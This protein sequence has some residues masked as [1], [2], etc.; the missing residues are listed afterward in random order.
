VAKQQIIWSVAAV[1]ALV[2]STARA[3]IYAYTDA[4]GNA[5]FSNVPDDQRYK[6]VVRTPVDADPA[7]KAQPERTAAWLAR[8]ASFDR[9]IEAAAAKTLVSP[10]LL[11]AVIVV[12]SGF[13]PRAISR[14]GAIGLMQLMPQT[15]RRYGAFNAFDPEQNIRAGAQYLADLML[16]FG[17]DKLELVIAA[18]NAGEGAVEKYGRKIPPY[19]ETRAYVPNVLRMYRVLQAQ[20][21]PLSQ[22]GET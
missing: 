15:A 11:R 21:R 10:Q 3:D 16:R 1:L 9:A 5:H 14:R 2:A 22:G 13:N 19:R 20:A 17:P 12:E 4:S 7:I 6:L 8:S 18:Y